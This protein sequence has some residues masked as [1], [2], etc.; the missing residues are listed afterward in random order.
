MRLDAFFNVFNTDNCPS[1][2]GK[3][4]MFLIQACRGSKLIVQCLSVL[5][6][7]GQL[8]PFLNLKFV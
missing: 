2:A 5:K 1:L 7:N 8:F 4:K 6:T 3:N